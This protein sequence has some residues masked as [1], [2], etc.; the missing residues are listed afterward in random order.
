M[1]MRS[2]VRLVV[3]GLPLIL[4]GRLPSEAWC[5]GTLAVPGVESTESASAFA[6]SVGGA[7]TEVRMFGSIRDPRRGVA[8]VSLDLRHT[9]KATNSLALDYLVGIVPIEVQTGNVVDDSPGVR[10]ASGAR[11]PIYGAGLDPVGIGV[12][13]GRGPWRPFG[14]LRGG[15]RIFQQRVPDPHSSRLNFV[16]NLGLGVLRRVGLSTWLSVGV[17]LHHVSNANLADSNRGVNQFVLNL[18]IVQSQ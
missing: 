16:A 18:G 5:G 14:T 15:V 7:W 13:L 9:F 6:L 3:L 10:D 1:V 11:A 12:R 17:D 2:A 8:I 4:T